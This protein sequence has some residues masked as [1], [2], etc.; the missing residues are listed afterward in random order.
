MAR[1]KAY[2]RNGEEK[3]VEVTVGMTVYFKSDYEQCGTCT[4]IRG[5][6]L[7]LENSSGF[8]GDYLRYAT[9]TEER[10]EDCWVEGVF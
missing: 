4:Q 3:T 6:R 1:V 5:D 10:A 2:G 7:T 8:G 9:V